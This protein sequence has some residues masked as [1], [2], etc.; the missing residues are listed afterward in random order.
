MEKIVVHLF[1][2]NR[3]KSLGKSVWAA[4]LSILR[5]IQGAFLEFILASQQTK[6]LGT[7][8]TANDKYPDRLEIEHTP[9]FPTHST[10]N[11]GWLAVVQTF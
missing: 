1:I 7:M 10:V 9:I 2:I 3:H 11:D 6:T 5:S 4:P 8:N